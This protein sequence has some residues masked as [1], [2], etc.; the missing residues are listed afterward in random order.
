MVNLKPSVAL[1]WKQKNILQ[2]DEKL[3]VLFFL[4]VWVYVSKTDCE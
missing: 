1:F 4:N 3:L 2:N